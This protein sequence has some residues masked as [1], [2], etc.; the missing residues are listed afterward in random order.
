MPKRHLL[1]ATVI[2]LAA[3]TIP[4]T[5]D[6]DAALGVGLSTASC[7]EGDCGS[8]NPYIDCFCIDLFI[9]DHWPRCDDPLAP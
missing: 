3:A 7:A 8:W 4:V 5:R 9:P 6:A 2:A 1:A